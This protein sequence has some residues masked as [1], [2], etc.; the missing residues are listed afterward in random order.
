MAS[1][2]EFKTELQDSKLIST[3]IPPR[4]YNK[5]FMG[6]EMF[7]IYDS[8]IDADKS[9]LNIPIITTVLPLVWLTKSNIRVDDLD[10][11]FKNSMDKLRDIYSKLYRTRFT[12]QFEADKIV[13]NENT[14]AE[15]ENPHALLFSGGVDS[16][17]SLVTNMEL[18]PRLLMTWGLEGYPYPEMSEYWDNVIATYTNF[19]EKKGLK[20][21]IMKTNVHEILHERRIEHNFHKELMDGTLWARVQLP[22][23]TI[24]MTAPL[25]IGRFNRL[26]FSATHASSHDFMAQPY[27]TGKLTDENIGWAGLTV[28]HVGAIPRYDKITGAIADYLRKDKLMIRCCMDHKKA[29][30]RLNCGED[31]HCYTVIPSLVQA[32]IDPNTC[33]FNLNDSTFLILKNHLEKRGFSQGSLDYIWGKI[34]EN[35]PEVI[36]NDMYGSK[37]LFEWFKKVDLDKEVEKDNKNYERVLAARKIYHRS[38]WLIAKLLDEIYKKIGIGIHEQSPRIIESNT[39]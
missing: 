21:H 34:H 4:E 33:G 28:R 23:V 38:S 7:V 27:S 2:F 26:M 3:V 19:A 10:L 31:P 35:I 18:K 1:F 36:E 15:P 8:K 30:S 29:G 22:L 37:I 12:T 39:D 6:K 11:H 17:Y 20:Y 5:Y 14:L 25:S 16:T 32:G 9:I 13:E 24:P